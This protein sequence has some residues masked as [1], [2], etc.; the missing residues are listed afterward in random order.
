MQSTLLS[1]YGEARLPRYTSYP[2]APLFSAAVDENVYAGWLSTLSPGEPVS[3]YLHVPFCR[4]M[5]WYC[6]CNTTISA[7]DEPIASYLDVLRREIEMVASRIGRRQPVKHVHFGGGT[8]TIMKPAQFIALVHLLRDRFDIVDDAEL[9]IEIDPRTITREML[10]AMRGSGINRASLGVQTFDWKVQQS[11]NRIQSLECTAETV[12]ALRRVGIKRI[13]FDLIYGL[14]NQ[15]V[16]S[17]VETV[18]TALTMKPDRLAVFGY[19]H[20][21]DVKKHQRLI[22]A[23]VLPDSATRVEQTVAIAD[24]LVAAGYRQIGL[25]CFALPNDEL[26]VA[27]AARRLRRNFQGYTSDNCEALIGFGASAIGKTKSGYVQNEA[28]IG[29]YSTR[30]S[31][32][33]LAT[34]RGYR[35]TTEDRGRAAIIERLMCD[36][37]A[38]LTEICARYGLD[39]AELTDGNE[40][41]S[42]AFDEGLAE[43]DG[44]IL[45]VQSK[46]RFLVR[47]VAA[48]F[49]SY[50]ERSPRTHSKAV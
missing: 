10:A 24:A 40:R 41:L 18:T 11:I 7:R 20:V 25:D 48:A 23:K 16:Q 35:L 50:L 34:A 21:P 36:F 9:A 38:N 46:H 2:T 28:V 44:N 29:N 37:E 12:A 31:A 47:V 22:D 15:T 30:I 4:S 6:G 42:R 1:A 33:R 3:L 8:P 32:G 19:A 45:R 17:C 49:D 14:P 27:Q 43:M 39:H 13:N 26:G 5:C